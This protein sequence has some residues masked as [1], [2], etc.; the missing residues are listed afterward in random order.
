MPGLSQPSYSLTR[1][2]G[3]AQTP[4]LRLIMLTLG[5]GELCRIPPKR[6]HRVSGKDGRRC[7]LA[8]LQG[9]S[10]YDYNPVGA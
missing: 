10:R 5:P 7:K 2:A 6:V 4:D 9:S 8:I 1:R 3:P